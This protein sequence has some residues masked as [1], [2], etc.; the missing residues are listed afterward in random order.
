MLGCGSVCL[1]ILNAA[2]RIVIGCDCGYDN[3]KVSMLRLLFDYGEF[4]Y[5]YLNS[6]RK[7]QNVWRVLRTAIPFYS[8]PVSHSSKVIKS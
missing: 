5:Q 7:W 6:P 2:H 8:A 3:A 4:D 1:A